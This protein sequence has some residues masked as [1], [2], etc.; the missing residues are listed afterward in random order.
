MIHSLEV[1][2]VFLNIADGY[3]AQATTIKFNLLPQEN[4]AR[5]LT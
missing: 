2:S 5:D 1:L 3:R 4:V